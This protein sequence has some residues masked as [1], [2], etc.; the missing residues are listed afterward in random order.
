MPKMVTQEPDYL[1]AD[2]QLRHVRIQVHPIDTLDLERHTTLEHV[3]DVCH[4]RHPRMVNAEG[5]L[6]RPG[7]SALNGGRPGGGPDPLPLMSSAE[8][9]TRDTRRSR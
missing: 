5:R 9:P 3:V 2:L 7:L 8:F 1:P 4:A 6:C